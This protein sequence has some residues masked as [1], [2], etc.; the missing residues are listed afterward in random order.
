[1]NGVG[2]PAHIIKIAII[3]YIRVHIMFIAI[4][5]ID[6]SGKT[7][8]A[9]R[10][11][12]MLRRDGFDAL[13]TKEHTDG[14]IGKEIQ[15]VLE[16]KEKVDALT[17]QIMFVAD[18]SDHVHKYADIINDRS[19]FLITDRYL[20]STIAYGTAAGVSNE[21]LVELNSV[22]PVP[23]ALFIILIDPIIA[24]KRIDRDSGRSSRELF[25]KEEFLDDVQ[26][27]YKKFKN[28]TFID[29]EMPADEITQIMY[30]TAIREF[31]RRS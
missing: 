6:G 31:G 17:L 14:I 15:R 22:F 1:M 28:A 4:E 29:G 2:F 16:H 26:A 5:G 23:D 27:N 7:T 9:N 10:L 20:Y 3:K 13:T 25:E 24:M 18:R 21:Y 12:E 19:K 11:A 8:Q 30:K